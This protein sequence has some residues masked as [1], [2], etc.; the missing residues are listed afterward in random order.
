[1][2]QEQEEQEDQEDQEVLV[3]LDELASFCRCLQTAECAGGG[4]VGGVTCSPVSELTPARAGFLHPGGHLW[5]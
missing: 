4:A 2:A 5:L 3:V 1:M